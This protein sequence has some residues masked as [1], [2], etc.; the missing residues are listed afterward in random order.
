LVLVAPAVTEEEMAGAIRRFS[1]LLRSVNVVV[2]GVEI[3]VDL[4]LQRVVGDVLGL[5]R[6]PTTL[7]EAR[8]A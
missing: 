2:D 4:S 6:H 1:A 7:L 3:E 5:L 8:N